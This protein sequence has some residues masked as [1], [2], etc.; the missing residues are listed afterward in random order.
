MIVVSQLVSRKR[1]SVASRASSMTAS[2]RFDHNGY[3]RRLAKGQVHTRYSQMSCD[4]G[5]FPLLYAQRGNFLV[6]ED[7][8]MGG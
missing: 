4:G 7:D 8:P 3:C 2:S 5:F 6:S 1:I